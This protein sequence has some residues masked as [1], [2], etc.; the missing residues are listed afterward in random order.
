MDAGKITKKQLSA[1]KI[2]K[3]A[4]PRWP[5]LAAPAKNETRWRKIMCSHVNQPLGATT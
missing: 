2:S 1:L 4:L 5:K 3:A